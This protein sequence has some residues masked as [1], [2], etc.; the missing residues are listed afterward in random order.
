[1]PGESQTRWSSDGK[2]SEKAADTAFWCGLAGGAVFASIG[3]ALAGPLEH[4]FGVPGLAHALL[5]LSSVLAITP[6]GSIHAARLTRTFGFRSLVFRLLTA[7]VVSSA[8]GIG[9]ALAGGGANGMLAQRISASLVFA[10]GAWLAYR[11]RPRLRFDRLEGR[12]LL[13]YG[14]RSMASQLLLQA[15][16][17][18]ID[19]IAG[20]LAGP[21]AVATLRI[22]NRCVDV[23]IQVAVAPFQQ[24]ALPLFSRMQADPAVRRKTY[25]D[26]G[27]L[28]AAIIY[29]AFAGAF[30]V[31]PDL[32]SL[33]FGE[34]WQ[35]AG[36][37]LQLICLSV[38]AL[39]FNILMPVVLSASGHPGHVLAWS[40]LQFLVGIA[41]A[42]LG[43]HYGI[44][45]LVIANLARAYLLLPLGWALL[46]RKAAIGLDVVI[47]SALQPL[48][49]SVLMAG[50]TLVVAAV[51]LP[52]CR[53]S[54]A[55]PAPC[56][57]DC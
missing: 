29:P 5:L 41:G 16:G 42:A 33:I 43:A 21:V 40:S 46:S 19:L 57:Q 56:S 52:F 6:L 30:V 7:T 34:Q 38:V 20:F 15:N 27:R 54:S 2:L 3:A 17:R 26:L 55:W 39:H 32:I 45:G 14:L 23:L 1:M 44:A 13:A 24:A 9:V 36:H 25:G 51:L 49:A 48:L 28:S 31:A 50:L 35:E 37:L 18:A 22:A 11:W 10:A 8:I 4:F 12:A 53:L 47:G